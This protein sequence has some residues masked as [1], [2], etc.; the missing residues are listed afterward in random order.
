[1]A[2][3]VNSFAEKTDAILV[4]VKDEIWQKIRRVETDKSAIM[5]LGLHPSEAL[6]S[7]P[8]SLPYPPFLVTKKK[9]DKYLIEIDNKLT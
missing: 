2:R 4:W 6:F 3:F 5:D 9:C 8:L 1:M 7:S